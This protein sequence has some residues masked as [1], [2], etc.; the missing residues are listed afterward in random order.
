MSHGKDKPKIMERSRVELL[1]EKNKAISVSEK[2]LKAVFDGSHDAIIIST[3]DGIFIDC[4]H[5][6][7][8]IFGLKS[9]DE[10]ITLSPSDF[11]LPS[12]QDGQSISEGLLRF[13][14]LI[15]LKNGESFPAE[16]IL[17]LVRI[18]EETFHMANIRD[19]SER[20]RAEEALHHQIKF[21]KKL[22]EISARF[23][24]I[25][26][27]QL[28][29]GIDYALQ[30]SGAFFNTDRSYVFQ[31]SS[32]G[33]MMDNT[34][35]WCSEG[36]QP[37]IDNLQGIPSDDM[38]WWME[39]LLRIETINISCVDDLPPQAA[40]E[41]E[42]LQSQSIQSV[43][44]LP[45]IFNK[46][47]MG[48]IG[49]DS[50]REKH[51]WNEDQISLLKVLSELISFA[52]QKSQAEE[53]LREREAL[54]RILIR[55]ATGFVN[56]PLETIDTAINRA[57][58]TIGKFAC[59]DRVYIFS[60]DYTNREATN[61]HEWCAEGIS[62]EINNIQGVPFELLNDFLKM[63]RKGEIVS[64]PKV[65]MM[66]EDY[67]L[68]TVLEQQGIQS[69]I[70]FP[71]M[72]GSECLGFVGY[73]AV[74][75]V[76][77]FQETEIILLKVMAELLANTVVRRRTEK[78]FRE[79]EERFR[80][81][82]EF[83]PLPLSI[84]D[85]DGKYEYL[86]PKFVE[87]FGYTLDDIPSRKKWF[88]L[89]YPDSLYRKKVEET[90]IND[91][92]NSGDKVRP[93]NFRV[94]CKDGTQKEILF[95][96]VLMENGKHLIIYEDITERKRYEKQLKYLSMHDQLTGLY[97][98]AYLEDELNRLSKSREYPITIISTDLDGLKLIND[99]LGHDKGDKL[100]KACTKV[101]KQSLRC[102][103]ILIRVGGD[104]FVAILPKTALKSGEEIADRIR[105]QVDLYNSK[106]T[107]LPL[108]LSIGIAASENENVSLRDTFKE[109]DDLMYR[110]KIYRR[111][112]VRNQVVNTLLIALAERDYITEGHAQRLSNLCKTMGE[113]L[114]LSSQKLVDLALL[115]LVHD[116][117]KVGIPDS[118]LFKNGP[119]TESE[120][121]IM[122]QHP[123]KGHRIAISSPDLSGVAELILL[124][125]EKW[126]GSG[127][128]YGFKGEKIPIECRILALVD[129]FDAMTN[130]RPYRKAISWDE[131]RE[132]II[133]YSGTQFDPALVDVFLSVL[134]QGTHP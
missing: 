19:I 83:S 62:S 63:L 3:K 55:L 113:K 10:L 118:I 33:G 16:V 77:V 126:D 71:M 80:Q 116:F 93:K 123:E 105:T 81:I 67:T 122:I 73:D 56:E 120:W 64:I 70:L 106:N 8:E 23:A 74:R 76:R 78:I 58:E 132:E 45:I 114:G 37:Q 100:L 15:N 98:R 26:A 91:I 95:R 2:K 52:L 41:K 40:A 39:K 96:L 133:K 57:L 89:A 119:L 110:E 108:S 5:R 7:L 82:S 35:E 49:F 115:A 60:F 129:A 88:E 69:L 24:T 6:A 14:R 46:K 30:H 75:N 68:R 90:W 86:N 12:I 87:V 18:G 11:F 79:R 54:Q 43:L 9:K 31:F 29:E 65:A 97:N 1:R 22:A 99:T 94:T 85:R 102:S 103:D 84:F 112:S 36:I 128:P 66:P 125:H 111:S 101:L 17:T 121:E 42:L 117:G 21:E 53:A 131:A 13:E 28:D 44:V 48:F 61:T 51:N 20:K 124:H 47:L 4:N 25:T 104:E 109:S 50:V 38:P 34:H 127:Y 32:D 107:E 130:D 134:E 59:V 27:A 92:N 72:Y